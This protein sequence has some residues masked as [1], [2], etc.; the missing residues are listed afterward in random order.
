MGDDVGMHREVEINNGFRWLWNGIRDRDLLN[1]DLSDPT[2]GPLYSA[3]PVDQLVEEFRL[4]SWNDIT[5]I[6]SVMIGI[7][8]GIN[9]FALRGSQMVESAFQ[10]LTEYYR[11]YKG[12]YPA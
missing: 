10:M 12:P 11:E 5:G 3:A 6:N 2:Y 1:P 4:T 7:G 8:I 9:V